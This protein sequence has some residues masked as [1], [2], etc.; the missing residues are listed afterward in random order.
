MSFPIDSERNNLQHLYVHCFIKIY[1]ATKYSR[2][3]T[4]VHVCLQFFS[5]S[6]SEQFQLVEEASIALETDYANIKE[7][8]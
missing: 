5:V 6:G 3:L 8:K 1:Y 2:P 7:K 4:I